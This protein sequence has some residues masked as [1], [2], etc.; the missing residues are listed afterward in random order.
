MESQRELFLLQPKGETRQGE[1]EKAMRWK[2]RKDENLEE[3]EK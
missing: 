1:Q 2:K 3:K